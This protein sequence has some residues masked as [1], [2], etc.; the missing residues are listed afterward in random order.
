MQVELQLEQGNVE[1]AWFCCGCWQISGK[2][3]YEFSIPT[4]LL[5]LNFNFRQS[6]PKIRVISKHTKKMPEEPLFDPSLKKRKK[7]NVVFIEDPLGADADPTKPAPETID[8][9]TINGEAVDLG[10]STAH[11]LMKGS[12]GDSTS[13]NKEKEEED[14]K[15]MFGDMKKKKKKK[16]IP[17]DFVRFTWLVYRTNY[18]LIFCIHPGRRLWPFC[19]CHPTSNRKRSGSYRSIYN[20][21]SW[22]LGHEKEEEIDQEKG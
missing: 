19:T 17:M 10:P 11:E 9:T 8:S 13:S 16:E 2:F 1:Q 7:K 6:N 20:R 18:H 21:W 15:A 22:F 14:F 3:G 4:G 12:S 5:S